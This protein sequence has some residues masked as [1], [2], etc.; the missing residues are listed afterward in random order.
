M[1]GWMDGW[2]VWSGVISSTFLIKPSKVMCRIQNSCW[3]CNNVSI[4]YTAG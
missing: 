1:D 2:T 4:I 3:L